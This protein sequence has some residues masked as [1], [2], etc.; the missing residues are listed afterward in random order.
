M[1]KQSGKANACT[2][3][4]ALSQRNAREQ[5]PLFACRFTVQRGLR[6]TIQRVDEGASWPNAERLFSRLRIALWNT[7][8]MSNL[9][10]L[11][12]SAT[13]ASSVYYVNGALTSDKWMILLGTKS[14]VQ[15]DENRQARGL[16][17][18]FEG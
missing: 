13:S 15:R 10:L 14:V 8:P 11:Q 1:P 6:Y 17:P 7:S 16:A 18:A 9:L 2:N 3:P 5:R 4:L 12:Q